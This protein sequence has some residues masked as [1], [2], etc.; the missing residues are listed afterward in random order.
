MISGFNRTLLELKLLFKNIEIDIIISF[1]R[2]LLE[3]KHSHFDY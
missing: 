2:T 3:L 1:N